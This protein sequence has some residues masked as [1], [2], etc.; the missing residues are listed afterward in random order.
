MPARIR[1]FCRTTGQT[2]PES[3]EAVLRCALEGIAL[4]YRWAL[5]RIDE[6]LDRRLDTLYI[7]GGGTQNHSLSQFI[8]DALN[9]QVITGPVEAAAA[10]NILMQMIAL[11]QSPS[12]PSTTG[13]VLLLCPLPI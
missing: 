6:T 10:G 4:K 1:E 9:R 3:K 2:A 5:E 13:D 12:R 8:A 7:V 11:G